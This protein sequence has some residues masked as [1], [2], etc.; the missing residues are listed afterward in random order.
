MNST[1]SNEL[2]VLVNPSKT[3]LCF[4]ATLKTRKQ[5]NISEYSRS[6]QST[7]VREEG[8]VVQ[9][10]R[11]STHC[12]HIC[13]FPGGTGN[14]CAA[15][16]RVANQGKE[17]H[18]SRKQWPWAVDEHRVFRMMGKTIPRWQGDSKL[19]E[20]PASRDSEEALQKDWVKKNLTCLSNIWGTFIQLE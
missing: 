8:S 5:W 16:N 9:S 19:K 15:R 14:G 12:P 18:R 1:R 7:S 2:W 20:P 17:R 3:A 4:S 10:E 6:R 11:F 13:P